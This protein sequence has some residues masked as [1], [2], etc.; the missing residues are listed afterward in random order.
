MLEPIADRTSGLATVLILF[1]LFG[2]R[3]PAIPSAFQ[4]VDHL[5]KPCSDFKAIQRV[6]NLERMTEKN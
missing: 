5:L 4:G 2:G 6:N 1:G 3:I